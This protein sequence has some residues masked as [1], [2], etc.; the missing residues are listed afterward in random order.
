MLNPKANSTV[1]INQ[2]IPIKYV[3]KQNGM[4]MLRSIQF[5]VYEYLTDPPSAC[6][7]F[8]ETNLDNYIYTK[9][10]VE[11]KKC[12]LKL[13]NGKL[14]NVTREDFKDTL[15]GEINWFVDET[16]YIVGNLYYIK[17]NLELKYRNPKG[18]WD[19]WLSEYVVG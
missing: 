5:S 8:N 12:E 13:V 6:S 11:M 17:V 9:N 10:L 19:I 3:V 7:N 16:K 1:E 15:E 4:A 2:L 14:A 18:I